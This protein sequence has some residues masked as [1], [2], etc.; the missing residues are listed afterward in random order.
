MTRPRLHRT[1]LVLALSTALVAPSTVATPG[2]FE[3][4]GLADTTSILDRATVTV[5]ADPSTERQ[6]TR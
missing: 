1:A 3:V 4:R 6:A 5:V 2:T